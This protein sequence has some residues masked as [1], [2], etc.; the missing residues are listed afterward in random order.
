MIKNKLSIIVGKDGRPS[1]KGVFSKMKNDSILYIRRRPQTKKGINEYW[2]IYT[3]HNINNHG[4][5]KQVS[6]DN[7]IVVRWGNCIQVP[8]ENCIVYNK[9]E[10]IAKATDKK[11]SRELFTKAGL[12]CPKLIEGQFVKINFP[13]IARPSKHSKGKNFVVINNHAEYIR[14]SLYN[15]DWYYSEYVDKVAEY[16]LHVAHG[17]VLNYLEKPAPRDKNQLA[18]NRA[19]NEDP[20]V[21]V[22]WD[23]YNGKVCNLAIKS[24]DVFGLDFGAVDIMVDKNGNPYLLEVNTAGT[25]SSSEYSMQRYAMYF[26][27]L[28][29]TNK[30][31]EHWPLKEF[32]KGSNYAWHEYHFEDREPKGKEPNKK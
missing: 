30:R 15:T 8:L 17:R 25:L 32:E 31:R 28:C 19:Q 11:L 18:W 20:F 13:V 29:K 21:N 5:L 2:R 7:N 4:K 12:S 24:L 14:H 6:F 10:A 22:K 16:R 3:D 23:N 1:M 9:S 26:D 27:W